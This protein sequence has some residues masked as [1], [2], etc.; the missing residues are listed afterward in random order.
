[1]GGRQWGAT[2]AQLLGMQTTNYEQVTVGQMQVQIKERIAKC[3]LH[4]E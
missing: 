2:G 3:N 1:M 4:T